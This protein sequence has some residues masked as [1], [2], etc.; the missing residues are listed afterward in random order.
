MKFSSYKKTFMLIAIMILF[1][2]SVVA[3]D[4]QTGLDNI[5]NT[6][7]LSKT[8][9]ISVK[10]VDKNTK[11]VVYQKNS[12]ILLHPASTMKV[13][14]SALV[15][16]TL[17][18]DYVMKTALYEANGRLYLKLCADP[19]LTK[20][21]LIKLFKNIDLT[22]YDTLVVDNTFID[23][24]FYDDGW[25]WN[26]LVSDDNP[27]YG[28][29]NLDQNLVSLKIIPNKKSGFVQIIADYPVVIANELKIGKKNDIK[30]Q[31]RPWQNPEAVYISGEISS[32]FITKIAVP[33]PE[34]YFLHCLN[35]SMPNFEGKIF[36][37]EAPFENSTCAKLLSCKQTPL[38]EILCDQNKNSNNLSAQTMFKVA[39]KEA[40][41]RQGTLENAQQLFEQFYGTKEFVIADASGL[42]HN[43]LLNCDFLC[44][45]LFRMRN[46]SDFS[47]TLAVA[48]KDGT[49]KKRLK[50]VSL[51]GK[52]GTISGVSG[53]CGYLKTSCGNDYIFSIL[54]QSYKG[55]AHPAKYL[56][57]K[58]VREL[59]K[60]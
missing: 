46:N 11:K 41:H 4:L 36:Y 3:Q 28:I 58:I 24:R 59:N 14:T 50:E 38:L 12:S 19:S 32:C 13:A 45:V 34:K 29:F 39:A 48:G 2:Q 60:S 1:C 8:S 16:E 27:P 23:N 42:S 6:D 43:N 9:V 47:S 35:Q 10:I 56:E 54:I 17:G 18:K 51:Q 57:D 44:D 5:I 40:F 52:T 26:N 49:L 33:N 15:L 31:H 20:N 30:I 21:D 55:S 22:K 25:M 7:L 53:L 37:G